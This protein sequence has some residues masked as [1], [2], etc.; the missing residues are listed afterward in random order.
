[1]AVSRSREEIEPL[2]PEEAETLVAIVEGIHSP[3]LRTRELVRL[4]LR[5]LI[6]STGPPRFLPTTLGFAWYDQSR[7][8]ANGGHEK[9][10]KGEGR[11][12]GQPEEGG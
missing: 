1:M 4:N 6:M 8:N 5:R 12:K 7:A 2:T 9:S 10:N 3:K 11:G